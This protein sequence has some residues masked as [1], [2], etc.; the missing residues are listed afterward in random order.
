[1]EEP[2]RSAV[3]RL[4]ALARLARAHVLSEWQSWPTQKARRSTSDHVLARPKRAVMAVEEHL[5]AQPAAGGYAE[6]VRSA[7]SAAVE[8]ATKH[9]KRPAPLYACRVSDGGTVPID[10]PAQRGIRAVKD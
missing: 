9:Q 1:M 6:V 10:E 8:E 3:L 7:R 4:G 5:C 2:A